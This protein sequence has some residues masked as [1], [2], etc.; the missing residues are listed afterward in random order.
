MV[1]AQP[2]VLIAVVLLLFLGQRS[3]LW[4]MAPLH[5]LLFFV[6][7]MVC[8]GELARDR[9]STAHLTEFYLLMAFGGVLGGAFNAL[10][11]PVVFDRLLEYPIAIAVAC[12]LRPRPAESDRWSRLLDIALPIGAL[13]AIQAF[14]FVGA[15]FGRISTVAI[16]IT[17]AVA[18]GAAALLFLWRSRPLRF[19]LLA[20]VALHTTLSVGERERVLLQDRSFFGVYKVYETRNRG[21][22][23]LMHGTTLHG[24]QA[25][26]PAQ[27]RLPLSYFHRE[28][29]FGQI[30]IAVNDDLAGKRTGVV[31]LGVGTLACYA[32]RER[33][34]TFFE[35]DP[36][37]VEI[38]RDP[39]LFTYMRSC[40]ANEPDV[41][42]GD[43][44]L[45]LAGEPDG[46]F[47][48]LVLD[49]FSSDAIPIHLLTR[50]AV[51][52]YLS[53]LAD[54]GVIALQITNRYI[55]LEPILDRIAVEL[56]LAAR[57]SVKAPRTVRERWA[58]TL[59]LDPNVVVLARNAADLASLADDPRWRM[60]RRS[61]G[62]T[63]WT[64]DYSNII[65]ALDLPRL[66]DEE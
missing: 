9:P 27:Q 49:A 65:E 60:L 22:R 10:L 25:I 42:L 4:I 45:T 1:A 54:G 17:L 62:A 12:M 24:A 15:H 41:V 35:I 51:E 46:A 7:A 16:A 40:G 43:G 55:D 61:A 38:S 18:L 34:M 26:A 37:V 29:P 13:A 28:G 21:V 56:G 53:K 8:H 39:R 14:A 31:G 47:G 3:S 50:E 63:L 36:L 19:G 57:A 5:T 20:A 64:D 44:R 23:Y 11:A 58:E 52:L 59:M 6:S 33:P 30:F 66:F 2:V 48:L 32:D